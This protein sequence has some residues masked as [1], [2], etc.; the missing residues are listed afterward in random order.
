MK[1]KSCIV[2]VTSGD[3]LYIKEWIEYHHNLGINL[4]LIAYNGNK[5]DY[6][7]LPEYEYVRYFDFSKDENAVFDELDV[8]KSNKAF[9]GCH[10]LTQ[11]LN[12]PLNNN[13]QNNILHI[14]L[15]TVLLC[16]PSIKYSIVIDTDEFINIENKENI[17]E[18][19]NNNFPDNYSS[20]SIEMKF[21]TNN[22]LIYYEN[23]P[24][25]ERF[26]E[27]IDKPY[28]G[29]GC[30]KIVIN[31]Y[32]NDTIN[33]NPLI[34]LSPHYCGLSHPDWYRFDA[35]KIF[36]KH[37]FTKTLEEWIMKLNIDID[38]DYL[39]RFKGNIFGVFFENNKLTEE[40]IKAIP[41]LLKKYNINYNPGIEENDEEFK[42][43]Y[44][45]INYLN[46]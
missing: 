6:H 19:L 10:D 40:K 20:L 36:L 46:Y 9:S 31:M 8:L 4:F 14:L 16:Y 25:I 28:F 37:F 42:K 3:F 12:N 21:Y 33:G 17:N 13:L 41:G 7:K 26:T 18:F 29:F 34:M 43:L 2:T 39:R 24:C 11:I 32:H 35:N 45:K 1:N 22:N 44:N 30:T 15:K 27:I 23:K 38:S 5:K